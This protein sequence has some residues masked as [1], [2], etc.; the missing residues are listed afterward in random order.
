MATQNGGSSNDTLTGTSEA[1]LISGW[2]GDDSLGGLNNADTLLGGFGNDNLAGGL[3]ADSLAGDEGA[4]TLLGGAGNDTLLGGSG[5]DVVQ[6]AGSQSQYQFGGHGGTL[7]VR[8]LSTVNGD[9][10]TDVV[11]GVEQLVFAGGTRVIVHGVTQDTQVNT[12]SSYYTGGSDVAGLAGGGH[13]VVWQRGSYADIWMQRF[14]AAG[15][16]LGTETRVNTH[17]GS[18]KIDP[19][20]VALDSGGFVVSWTS[21]WQDGSGNGVYLQRYDALGQPAGAEIR[22]NTYTNYD[23]QQSSICALADGGFVVVWQS[24]NQDG[25]AGGIYLQRFGADGAVVGAEA[26]VNASTTNG[27]W[28]P[29][30]AALE[31]GGYVVAWNSSHSGSSAAYVQRYNAAGV[32]LGGEERVAYLSTDNAAPA[33]AGLADGGFVVCVLAYDSQGPELF[34][35]RFNATGVAGPLSRVNTT[36]G[37]VQ[38]EPSVTALANGGFVATWQVTHYAAGTDVD[39]SLQVFDAAGAKVGGEIQVNVQAMYSQVMPRVDALADGGF[40]VTWTSYEGN[41]NTFMQR[42]DANGSS[43]Q[44]LD[45][46]GGA[47]DD[48][49]AGGAGNDTL[50]GGAGNDTLRGGQG[51]D[52][53]RVNA[54]GDSVVETLAGGNDTVESSVSLTLGN[55]VENLLLLGAATNGNGNTLDNR[56]DGNDL[57]NSLKGLAG[58]DTLAGGA[59]NDTLNGGDGNDRLLGGDGTDVAVYSGPQGDYVV[60]ATMNG[61]YVRDTVPGNGDDG[62]DQFA[63]V[64]QLQFAG[65]VKVTATAGSPTWVGGLASYYALPIDAGSV[66][67]LADGGYLV[68]WTGQDAYSYSSTDILLQRY[69]ADGTA[70]GTTVRL[71]GNSGGAQSQPTAAVLA[72]GGYVVCW[73]SEGVAPDGYGVYAQ[74]FAADGSKLGAEILVNSYTT[75]YQYGQEVTALA[76][77]GFVV[78]WESNYQDG[79]G[80]GIYLQRYTSEGVATG[81]ELQVN[82]TTYDSQRSP[83]VASTADGGLV[84]VWSEGYYG[85]DYTEVYQ[86]RFAADGSALGAE[87]RVNPSQTYYAYNPQGA[88]PA[89]AALA[90][91]GHVV[92]WSGPTTSYGSVLEVFLQ[93]YA[94]DGS[95]QGSLRVLDSVSTGNDIRPM[96]AGLSDGGFVAAWVASPGGVWVQR[97]NATAEPAGEKFLLTATGDDVALATTADGGYVAS[98]KV[99]NSLYVQRFDAWDGFAANLTVTGT[100]SVETLNGGAG[101][102]SI[103][104]GD[105]ADQLNG[106]AGADTLNGGAGNDTMRGG[107]GNDFYYVNAADQIVELEGQGVDQVYSSVSLTLAVNVEHLALTGTALNGT[108]NALANVISGTELGNSLAGGGSDDTLYGYDG[109]DTLSGG[110]GNDVMF[111]GAGDDDMRGQAGDDVY[112]VNSAGDRVTEVVDGGTDL[113]HSEISYVL[114]AHQENLHLQAGLNGTGNAVDNLITGNYENNRLLGLEGNDTLQ[115]DWGNDWLAGGA[116]DDTLDGG[117]GRDT[118]SIGGHAGDFSLR[119][120]GVRVQLRDDNTA[121]GNEGSD[122]LV[123]V[124]RLQF[125]DGMRME[126]D[127]R[128]ATVAA[129]QAEA[130]QT[131]ELI[132]GD[133][134]TFYVTGHMAEWGWAYDL[135]VQR[136]DADLVPVGDAQQVAANVVA[137]GGLALAATADGGALL[138]WGTNG[139]ILLQRLD[140]SG[141]PGGDGPMVVASGVRPVL[142]GLPD[143]TAQ[144]YWQ[145]TPDYTG[146]VQLMQAL[147][148]DGNVAGQAVQVS[149]SGNFPVPD[150]VLV[151]TADGGYVLVRATVGEVWLQRHD[152]AGMQTDAQSFVALEPTGLSAVQLADGNVVVSWSNAYSSYPVTGGQQTRIVSEDGAIVASLQEP[153]DNWYWQQELIALADGGYARIEVDGGRVLLSRLDAEGNASGG[154][155]VLAVG[156]LPYAPLTVVSLADGG[157]VVQWTDSRGQRVEQH[158]DAD[159][160]MDI[161]YTLHGTAAAEVL[162]GSSGNDT[163]LGGRGADTLEG[164]AGDDLLEGGE[165]GDVAVYAGAQAGYQIAT[166]AD[167]VVVRDTDNVDGSEGRD[168]LVSVQTLQFADGVRVEVRESIDV[169]VN[170]TVAG[171]QAHSAVAA[172]ADGGYV[173]AWQ[174]ADGSGDGI[175]LQRFDAAGQAAGVETRVNTWTALAQSTPTVTTLADGGFVVAWESFAQ[176]GSNYGIFLQRY[177]ADGA[178]VGA[179]TQVNTRAR[180]YQVA[181]VV[182]ASD[183]GGFT[184]AWEEWRADLG[185][186][187][188]SLQSFGADGEPVGNALRLENV[189]DAHAPQLLARPDGG[190]WLGVQATGSWQV[191]SVGEEIGT[192]PYYAYGAVGSFSLVASPYTGGWAA[193]TTAN[194][195]LSLVSPF[196]Y[197][198]G[199]A[200]L[201]TDAGNA[202]ATTLADG[203]FLVAWESGI[204]DG[205]GS[206]ISLRR[207]DIDGTPLGGEMRVNRYTPGDQTDPS[208]ALLPDGGFVVSWTSE[209]QDGSGAGVYAQRFD[210]D[211]N[212]SAALTIYGDDAA[213]R[214]Q[215]DAGADLLSG[216]AGNDSLF[217]GAGADT[218]TGGRGNDQLT[219]GSEADVF[220]LTH[221]PDAGNNVDHI[222]DFVSGSDR[223]ELSATVFAGMPAG[224]VAANAFRLAA[225]AGDAD[226]RLLY[227]QGNLYYDADGNGGGAKV[228]LATFDVATTLVASDFVV[229]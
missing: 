194:G 193:V 28:Q 164:G 71:P 204:R 26:R 212:A 215:G 181:P 139:Q 124:E 40:V 203:S 21:A 20:V 3:G 2:D 46:L 36:L 152:A 59:G 7:L 34:M 207:F 79:S 186:R 99:G 73:T 184:V 86:Q 173:V 170:S 18:D 75:D 37:N 169:R 131:V 154:P 29:A 208:L 190:M 147:D 15:Q 97:Y 58:A 105:G 142:H 192:A 222:V 85:Y 55:H 23:Q 60:G 14:D 1:D 185:T 4:D 70:V 25:S 135:F 35:Q 177:D 115:G 76:D 111:G 149:A 13:V 129:L 102:D 101:M 49:L 197:P 12:L 195:L 155:S 64:E 228:L 227:Q 141:E 224:A 118:A 45:V 202:A 16:R 27:Q 214:L 160:L 80:S 133:Q 125:A 56:V 107:A 144:L 145:A 171:D 90:D 200:T 91:G 216:G 32:A 226:D 74:R 81:G 63:G 151:N 220:R 69:A 211:G 167:G 113:I 176:D 8:D 82:T 33:I 114:G 137:P 93:R 6:Y 117:E 196:G 209:E 122:L 77:G 103:A 134:L 187:G 30:V 178:A 89:V 50:D 54:S 43:L 109:N 126:V 121:D 138:G 218:L 92:L 140:A 213:D 98:W 136:H 42:F 88:Q 94:A 153:Q 168:L 72:D 10:G 148:A 96:V 38:G 223:V 159:G 57:A 156:V 41:T 174:S 161:Q 132:D 61:L 119:S 78:V 143:G 183:E 108:G 146:W 17:A 163:L 225:D 180:D 5:E 221:A 68:A 188:V 229:V 9:D 205:S 219:G 47:G 199:Y 130:T 158:L 106:Y 201:A 87:T 165:G 66:I 100:A 189:T 210:A 19:A 116:G 95:V 217:G 206:G 162:D 31:E 179:E 127:V 83:A 65:G 104:G 157:H 11:E 166:S 191:F 112:Y 123:S 67:T 24:L 39:V 182:A 44:H 52:L 48:V 175:F 198:Y 22:V 120:D 53:Y 62:I 128:D 110:N 150:P 51:D 172:L 84:V